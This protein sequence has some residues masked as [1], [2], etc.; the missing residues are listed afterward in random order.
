[1]SA[2]RVLDI[3]A[4]ANQRGGRMLSA[5]D[6]ME[7]GTLTRAQLAWTLTRIEAGSGWLVG[8]RPGGAGKTAVMC[9]LLAFLPQGEPV[10]LTRPEAHWTSARPAE[11]LVC[12]ELSPGRYDAYLWGEDVRRLTALGAAGCRL[13]ANLHA[14]TLEEARDQV[15]LQCRAPAEHFAAFG[16]FLGI[17]VRQRGYETER[18]VERL[19]GVDN[20]AWKP[21]DAAVRPATRREREIGAFLEDCRARR[22]LLIEEVR[23]QWLGWRASCPPSA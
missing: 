3:I 7:R 15:V 10:R 20:G 19:Y 6:L 18:A 23:R 11:C 8:A 9:A 5:V 12:Y 17:S 16:I 2:D 13:V 1:M 4:R 14:D 22:V 21:F